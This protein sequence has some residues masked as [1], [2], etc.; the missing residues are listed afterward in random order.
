MKL[1]LGNK[2]SSLRMWP[3]VSPSAECSKIRRVDKLEIEL[4]AVAARV[5]DASEAESP[6]PHGRR[7]PHLRLRICHHL[8]NDRTKDWIERKK[9]ASTFTLNPNQPSFEAGKALATS[10][11]KTNES[12]SKNRRWATAHL[13]FIAGYLGLLWYSAHFGNGT[14]DSL[15][16]PCPRSFYSRVGMA[17]DGLAGR[18]FIFDLYAA[19][20]R[21]VALPGY[22][23]W[24]Q[25]Q[26]P[27]LD[28]G[29]LAPRCSPVIDRTFL[30]EL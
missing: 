17:A 13:L 12:A 29:A 25:G 9:G 30:P 1:R 10:V 14:L 15:P 3:P 8:L 23:C 26:A 28:R 21:T 7:W 11:K 5:A 18:D 2:E 4:R 24:L 6:S 22:P 19:W 16:E 27:V 20:I